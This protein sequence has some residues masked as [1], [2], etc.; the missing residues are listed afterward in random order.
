MVTFMGCGGSKLKI[1][2]V[3]IFE[4]GM[5]A[6]FDYNEKQVPGLQGMLMEKIRDLAPRLDKKTKIHASPLWIKNLAFW[7]K[8]VDYE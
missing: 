2:D 7:L 4:N 8:V 5:I 6:V 1:K 3:F